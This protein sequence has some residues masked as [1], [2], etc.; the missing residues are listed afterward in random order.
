M[1]N[2]RLRFFFFIWIVV[3]PYATSFA[4]W[5]GLAATTT[6]SS[7]GLIPRNRNTSSSTKHTTTTNN[8]K[9]NND[10][11]QKRQKNK[12]ILFLSNLVSG[13][14][15][16]G[17]WIIHQTI[18]WLTA[19]DAVQSVIHDQY[20]DFFGSTENLHQQ[21]K[22][23][24][25]RNNVVPSVYSKLFYFAR[26]RPRLVYAVGALLRALQLCT[27]LGRILDP[28][29]GVG[30]GINLCAIVASSRWVKP[31]VLGWATTKYIWSWLGA[32]RVDRA[33]LPISLSI[34]EWE[35][36]KKKTKGQQKQE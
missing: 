33:F 20:T 31:L 23:S 17:P 2:P 19:A 27:P 36:H 1:R 35:D 29:I 14:V 24:H 18:Y 8:N 34:K 26:L 25:K 9:N 4:S 16:C 22:N 30:A 10:K 28:S 11:K 12:V 15:E 6:T 7:G 13:T 21:W 3:I 5:Q 32:K